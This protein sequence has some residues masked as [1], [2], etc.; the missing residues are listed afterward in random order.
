MMRYNSIQKISK[1]INIFKIKN[2][3]NY[4]KNILKNLKI[5]YKKKQKININKKFISQVKQL[6]N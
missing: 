1:I 2:E 3:F 5:N 4:N 6:K